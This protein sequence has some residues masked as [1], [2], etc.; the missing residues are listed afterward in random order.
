MR[1]PG[2][3]TVFKN[4][5]WDNL[6][7]GYGFKSGALPFYPIQPPDAMKDPEDPVEEYEPHPKEAPEELES[8]SDEEKEPEDDVY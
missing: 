2:A 5:V 1:W 4:G 7:M 8:D 3:I 6:Y